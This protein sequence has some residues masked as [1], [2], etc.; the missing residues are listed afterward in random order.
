MSNH[1][2]ERV[3]ES[4]IGHELNAVR[5]ILRQPL[6]VQSNCLYDVWADGR[7]FVA[8]QY[9]KTDELEDAPAREFQA[10]RLVESL[11]IAPRPIFYDPAIAPIVVYEYLDGEMWDRKR[12]SPAELTQLAELW[13]KTHTVSADNLWPSRGF[14]L[15]VVGAMCRDYLRRYAQWVAVEFSAAQLLAD[16]CLGLLDRFRTVA[17][18]VE[19]CPAVRCF[20]RA[21]ARFA[22]VIRRPDGRL[23][24]VDWEDS[25]LRDPARDVADLLTGPNQE[26]L[27]SPDDWRPFLQAYYAGR[28]KLD[29]TLAA[30]VHLY[31]ALFPVFW[32]A[33]LLNVGVNRAE[34]GSLAGWEINGLPANLRLRRYL[35][36]ALA[37]PDNYF[38][39]Q[40]DV[41]AHLMF[42]PDNGGLVC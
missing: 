33:L 12:P 26:D 1:T 24:M 8:K 27:F 39:T 15:D 9:L 23:G 32:L 5:I 40:F 36:R 7:H 31:L 11:D 28:M 41:F 38:D 18:A 17:Q 3:I 19:A 6:D 16:A 25:G 2:V 34:A 20:C 35:A 21:D 22:N 14:P 29:P 30:R 42:F 13:L 10:L 4:A 37:W